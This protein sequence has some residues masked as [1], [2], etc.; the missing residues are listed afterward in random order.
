VE[1]KGGREEGRLSD[2][3]EEKGGRGGEE[4]EVSKKQG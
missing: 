2:G 1:V 4:E 3:W